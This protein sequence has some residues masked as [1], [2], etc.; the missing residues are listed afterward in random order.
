[1]AVKPCCFQFLLG[2]NA[3]AVA[4]INVL[5]NTSTFNSFL[6][7]TPPKFANNWNSPSFSFNSF[8]DL[9]YP[10]EGS[11]PNARIPFNSFLDLTLGYEDQD[12]YELLESFN[13]FLDLTHVVILL[14]YLHQSFNSFLDLTCLPLMHL[15]YL[16]Q[17]FQF[18]L[19]FN[20]LPTLINTL[21]AVT[22][23]NS[24]LDLTKYPL[25]TPVIPR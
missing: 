7:L 20:L 4:R 15:T 1:M 18:L 12:D 9:T 21:T 19:G 2:F 23:F 22:A 14:M 13:S 16:V 17:C 5:N 3:T 6:D 10:V 11:I 8:L 25:L 24:F